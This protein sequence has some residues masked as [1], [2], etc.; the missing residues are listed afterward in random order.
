MLELALQEQA[1]L[2]ARVNN[3]PA[4]WLRPADQRHLAEQL[5]AF[6]QA[7]PL[8]IDSPEFAQQCLAELRAA[9]QAGALSLAGAT[10]V[11]VPQSDWQPYRDPFTLVRGTQ[12]AVTALAEQCTR[13]GYPQLGQLLHAQPTEQPPL[14]LSAFDYFFRR[15]VETDPELARGLHFQ[16]MNLL[17]EQQ[18]AQLQQI[19]QITAT[20]AGQLHTVLDDLHDIQ[21][22]VTAVGGHVLDLQAQ[23]QH[24]HGEQRELAEAILARLTALNAHSGPVNPRLSLSLHGEQERQLVRELIRRYRAL[25]ATAQQEAPSLLNGLAKLELGLGEPAAAARDFSESA[26]YIPTAD[27]QAQGEAA[28]NAY[29]SALEQRH[30]ERALGHLHTAMAADRRLAPLPLQLYTPKR[31]L[32]AGGFGVVFLCDNRDVQRPAVV[33]ALQTETLGR[34][35]EALFQE[36]AVLRDLRHPAIIR[37]Y[38][39]GFVDRAN[40]RGPYLEMEYFPGQTLS[41]YLAEHGPLPLAQARPLLIPIV[42]ALD[43][44][45]DQAILHRDLKPD[46][47]LVKPGEPAGFDVRLIDFGLALAPQA[48]A[49]TV[50]SGG[51]SILAGSITGTFDYAPPEQRGSRADAVGPYSD[52]YSF[53]RLSYRVL[54]GTLQPRRRQL[55]ELPDAL[56]DCLED[57]LSDDPAQ[58]PQSAAA[59]R[60]CLQAAPAAPSRPETAP[61]PAPQPPASDDPDRQ[62]DD[63][64]WQKAAREAEACRQQHTWDRARQAVQRYLQDTTLLQRHQGEAQGLLLTLEQA[65]QSQRED[66]AWHTL[67]QTVAQQR[68]QHAWK[69][70]QQA[71]KQFLAEPP[72]A[73]RHIQ[74]AQALLLALEQVKAKAEAHEARHV[75]PPV[76]SHG[77]DTARVQARQ[78]E[79]A[80][81]LG[82]SEPVFQDRCKDGRAGPAMLVIPSGTFL[83]GSPEDEDGRNDNEHQPEVTE[84][85]HEV[86]IDRPFAIGRYAVTFAEY[87]AYCQATGQ[88]KPEDE[89]WGREQRPVI[90]VSWEAAVAYCEW[91]SAQK[92]QTYRLPTEAEWEYAARAG[93]TTAYWWGDEI[94]HNRA[95]CDGCGSQWDDQQTAPVGSFAANPWGLYEVH[96]NVWEWTCSAYYADYDDGEMRCQ[97]SGGTPRVVRG[98]SWY[99]DPRSVRAAVRFPGSPAIRGS[100]LGFR[101]ARTL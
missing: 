75:L 22:G 26:R 41:D 43:A 93:T 8:A 50:G 72:P 91:L 87:D 59:V 24:W 56:A 97:S 71:V 10:D 35:L 38:H 64:N 15:E 90:M 57:C 63:W 39:Q 95:N 12:Q 65:E 16:Q 2:L 82:F 62:R 54:F 33:K 53:A 42:E 14:L 7:Q 74:P 49:Q 68:E 34:P 5:G 30:W 4:N 21:A 18:R 99:D 23:M 20:L 94:G 79:T 36:A 67:Q 31:I 25:P 86:T 88:A 83:M 17:S 46:N 44:I 77:W 66:Q 92:G 45:H 19:E 80:R 6:I 47:I 37:I 51:Q 9:R 100:N 78:Q 48:I 70:A 96:G 11:P 69:K 85:Q 89:D 28:Y 98:G 73:E 3:L 84:R 76:K 58:R 27:T 52:L 40:Q 13:A 60:A 55:D 61:E 101:L 81:A 29:R 32:G 1:P